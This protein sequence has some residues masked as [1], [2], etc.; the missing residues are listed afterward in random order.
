MKQ[1]IEELKCKY[2]CQPV[3]KLI[4]LDNKV[5]LD[6]K[7]SLLTTNLSTEFDTFESFGDQNKLQAKLVEPERVLTKVFKSLTEIL[8][9]IMLKSCLISKLKIELNNIIESTKVP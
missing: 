2:L 8:D 3:F 7:M 9:T 5:D 6:L 4:M 1:I